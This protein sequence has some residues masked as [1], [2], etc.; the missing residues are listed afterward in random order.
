MKALVAYFS[1]SGVT[2]G[3]AGR[4]ASAIDAP[5]Y[6]IRPAV[7]YT[8][9]DLD[10]TNKQ[11]RSTIEMQDKSC[12]PA[13]ADTSAPVKDADIIFVGYPVWWYREPSIIDSF[14]AAYDFTGRKIVLFATSGG[15]DIGAEA[16]ARAAE[17]SKTT[18]EPGKR[19]PANATK[20]EL[21]AWAE[22]F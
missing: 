18:V 7:P 5:V 15:S 19:F 16:P 20:E 4:L 13:L 21:K 6:E 12:R 11:S 8:Q 10:W 17:I 2:A 1:A 9:A 3:L 14:L 22:A